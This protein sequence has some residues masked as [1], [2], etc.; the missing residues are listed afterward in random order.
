[1]RRSAAP[2]NI[3]CVLRRL[4]ITSIICRVPNGVPQRTQWNGSA[5]FSVTG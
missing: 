2:E 5:S 3:E 1:M 4:V